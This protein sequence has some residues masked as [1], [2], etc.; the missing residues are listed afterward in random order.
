MAVPVAWRPTPL[1]DVDPVAAGA[2]L[3]LVSGSLFVAAG[4]HREGHGSLCSVARTIPGL[5]GIVYFLGHVFGVWGRFD[6][7]HAVSRRIPQ[8]RFP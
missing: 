7:I 1:R 4:L 3:G 2:A 8:R 5:T 6:A